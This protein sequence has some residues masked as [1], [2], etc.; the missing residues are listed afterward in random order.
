[1]ALIAGI[2]KSTIQYLQKDRSSLTQL[3]DTNTS[4]STINSQAGDGNV[5]ASSVFVL[6]GD[7]HLVEGGHMGALFSSYPFLKRK[8]T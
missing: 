5:M 3:W 1:M 6:D 7:Q 2:G 8:L 4:W